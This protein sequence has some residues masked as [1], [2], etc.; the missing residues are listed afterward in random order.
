MDCTRFLKV[1]ELDSEGKCEDAYR[2]LLQLATERDPLAL[3]ELS[4]RNFSTNG[5]SPPV[6][7]LPP[8]IE[9]SKSFAREGEQVLLDLAAEKDGEAMRTLGNI[10]LGLTLPHHPDFAEYL[11]RQKAKEWLLKAFEAGCYFAA[12]DLAFYFGEN[13]EE[14]KFWRGQAV[15]H[16]CCVISPLEAN[17]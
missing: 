13:I 1:S 11:D 2:L 10:F 16:G 6:F 14:A 5:F 12:N 17:S 9:K 4:C 8:D 15:Q 3:L 7:P